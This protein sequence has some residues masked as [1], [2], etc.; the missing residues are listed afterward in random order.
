MGVVFGLTVQGVHIFIQEMFQS[1][2]VTTLELQLSLLALVK[3][4]VSLPHRNY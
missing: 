3:W 1:L 2:R 4:L